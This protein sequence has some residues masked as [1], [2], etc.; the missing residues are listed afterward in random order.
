MGALSQAAEAAGGWVHGITHQQ[1]CGA[2]A[3]FGEEACTTLQRLDVVQGT[4]LNERKNRLLAAGHCLVCLPGGVGTF[5][6]L[7]MA[8]A[9]L[10]T[11]LRDS[12]PILLINTRIE[13]GPGYYDGILQQLARAEEDGLLR[14]PWREYVSV[15]ETPAE[16]VAWCVSCVHAEHTFR[17]EGLG[18][19]GFSRTALTAINALHGTMFSSADTATE[20]M[21]VSGKINVAAV[22]M[23]LESMGKPGTW[24]GVRP[25]RQADSSSPPHLSATAAAELRGAVCGAVA[26]VAIAAAMRA[27]S[28]AQQA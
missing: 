10:A 3:A 7:F 5:D 28:R 18:C 8:V 4:D 1:F 15:V 24:A 14:K 27:L 2:S 25:L 20:V 13:D 26:L 12:L 11:K 6:E 16:A 21:R 19:E 23:A 22:L 9:L 17:V